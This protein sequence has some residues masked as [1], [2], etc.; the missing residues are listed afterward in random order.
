MAVDPVLEADLVSY[1]D[2]RLAPLRR[3][4]V[5]AHLATRPDEAARIM[6][7]LRLRDELRLALVAPEAPGSR[8]LATLARRLQSGLGRRRRLAVLRRCAAVGVFVALGWLAHEGTGPLA[9]R[10]SIASSAPP[11]FV[12]D[13]LAAHQTSLVR[14][15]MES[16]VETPRYDPAE[17]RAATAITM[18]EAPRGWR[19]RDVQVFPS[20]FGP[21]VEIALAD[22][23]GASHSLFGIRPGGFEVTKPQT[24]VSGPLAAAF[25]QQGPVAYAL[26]G[27]AAE[28]DALGDAAE[29]LARSL[30]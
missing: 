28:R 20:P 15:T 13:A 12:G 21:S 16:Q 25:W 18:P 14:S 26:V 23:A 3:I 10:Q 27:P 7:D 1:V 8:E 5:E 19:V 30:Y 17:I 9:V 2:D 24:T 11:P 22:R 29:R 4:E 6:A